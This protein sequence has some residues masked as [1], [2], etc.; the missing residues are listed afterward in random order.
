[1][2]LG[3]T[4]VPKQNEQCKLVILETS[5]MHGNIFPINY[6]NNEETSSGFAKISSLLKRELCLSS[7]TLVIDNGDVLQ[8]TPLTYH[9]ARYLNEKENPLI[10]CLNHL[11]YDAAVIGNHEFNYGKGLLEKAIS[12]SNFP[13]LSANILDSKSKQPAFGRPYIIKEFNNGLR[14]AVLGVTTHYIPNW[15]N[16]THIKGL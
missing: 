5:D 10:S 12:Q 13:W 15:E 11:E 2:K 8:G 7:F 9:Y 14:V 1:M 6:G 4:R 3:V 16:P